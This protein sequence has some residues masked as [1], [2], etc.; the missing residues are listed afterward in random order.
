[1]ITTHRKMVSG[2]EHLRVLT[3]RVERSW[4]GG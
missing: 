1:M 2:R 4:G 3:A